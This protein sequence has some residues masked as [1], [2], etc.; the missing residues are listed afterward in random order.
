MSGETLAPGK[1]THTQINPVQNY[2]SVDNL[3]RFDTNLTKLQ[4]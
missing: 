2:K 4:I 3:I 1:H